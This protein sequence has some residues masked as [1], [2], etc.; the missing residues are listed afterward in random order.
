MKHDE[1]IPGLTLRM[2]QADLK[3][4]HGTL[5][6]TATVNDIPTW[7]EVVGR[8]NGMRVYT[9]EGLAEEM[10]NVAQ[11]RARQVQEE[12]RKEVLALRL[13]LE[14]LKQQ[15]S[16]TKAENARLSVE[17]DGLRVKAKEYDDLVGALAVTTPVT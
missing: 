17:A 12:S 11:K 5:H 9:V 10:I 16:F 15:V 13:E 7:E 8:L 4:G 3:N 1:K 6:L 2:V 14:K